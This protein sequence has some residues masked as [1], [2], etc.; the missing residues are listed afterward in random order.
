MGFYEDAPSGSEYA[1]HVKPKQMRLI[2]ESDSGDFHVQCGIVIDEGEFDITREIRRGGLVLSVTDSFVN[3]EPRAMRQRFILHPDATVDM[4]LEQDACEVCVNNG[5]VRC[6]VTTTKSTDNEYLLS[7][8]YYSEDYGVYR[9]CKVYDIITNEAL[10]GV[11]TTA[12][13]LD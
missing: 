10:T 12:I 8:G 7:D 11:I 9:E 4:R 2:S 5:G 1:K 13:K 3:R 6:T